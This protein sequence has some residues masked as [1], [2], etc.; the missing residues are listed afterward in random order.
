MGTSGE[1]NPESMA[2]I[3]V[4][5]NSVGTVDLE[6]VAE[7]VICYLQ[8]QIDSDE[9]WAMGLTGTNKTENSVWQEKQDDSIW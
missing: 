3:H 2:E 1:G 5:A 6:L 7:A 9:E 4:C 8:E